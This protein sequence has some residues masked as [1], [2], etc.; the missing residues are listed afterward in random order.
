VVSPGALSK[1]RL[2]KSSPNDP[3]NAETANRRSMGVPPMSKHGQ[4][5]RR[6]H[7]GRPCYWD[8][9]IVNAKVGTRTSVAAVDDNSPPMT[10]TAKG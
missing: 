1:K 5:A 3:T 6:T 8:L 2:L 4:Y 7:G 9:S 10:V